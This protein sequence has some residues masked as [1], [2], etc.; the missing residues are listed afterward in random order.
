MLSIL[1]ALLI[2]SP[3][4]P[5]FT[6]D[7]VVAILHALVQA[8]NVPCVQAPTLVDPDGNTETIIICSLHGQGG[9]GS[10]M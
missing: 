2:A 6:P 7:Q 5:S 1:T 3:S 9:H 8:P 10:H 4:P